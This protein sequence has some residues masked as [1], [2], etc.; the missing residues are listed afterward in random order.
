M[1]FK[2]TKYGS[3]LGEELKFYEDEE[4]MVNVSV[5]KGHQFNLP[6]LFF[7]LSSKLF[8]RISEGIYDQITDIIIDVDHRTFE[9]YCDYITDGEVACESEE[10][11]CNLKDF[12]DDMIHIENDEVDNIEET[13]IS[14]FPIDSNSDFSK[15]TCKHCY[16]LFCS[17]QRCYDHEQT[18]EKNQ[19]K[20]P[21]FKCDKCDVEC[22]TRNGLQTHI[23]T[24]HATKIT[25]YSC[26]DCPKTFKHKVNLQRHCDGTGHG[27]R[28]KKMHH[29]E[30]CSYKTDRLDNLD[31]HE[32]KHVD[33]IERKR[34]Y[35]PIKKA[36]DKNS[37][38]TFRCKDCG[39]KF[40][41]SEDIVK[42]VKLKSCDEL[43]C[44]ICK[45]DFTFKS[46]LKRHINKFH[47]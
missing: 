18:C 47:K 32:K 7:A 2:I 5:Q 39:K 11:L 12:I 4:S 19:D 25:S 30:E 27:E 45:K 21:G 17:F 3:F 42:H 20:L 6:K 44:K 43:R 29:C 9:L 23:K 38:L 24:K 22:K 33:L 8:Q 10:E 36:M 34:N 15:T 14:S 35:G 13:E 26:I 46:N 40:A 1:S 16:K 41:N 31:R 37:D 28:S